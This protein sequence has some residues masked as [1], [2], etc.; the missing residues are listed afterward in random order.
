MIFLTHISVVNKAQMCHLFLFNDPST[1]QVKEKAEMLKQMK[2]LPT[3]LE[4]NSIINSAS[5]SYSGW[6]YGAV[7]SDTE[8]LTG[9]RFW[10]HF[11]MIY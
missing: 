3:C 7:I 6:F 8:E 10:T 2:V 5:M 4:T 9:S 1:E 11:S